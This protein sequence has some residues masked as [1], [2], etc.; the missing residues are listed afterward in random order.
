MHSGVSFTLSSRAGGI[1]CFFRPPEFLSRL[2]LLAQR[3]IAKIVGTEKMRIKYI[4]SGG[5]VN[6]LYLLMVIWM[7]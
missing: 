3:A 5:G 2:G 1:Y 4:S 7:T 6:V